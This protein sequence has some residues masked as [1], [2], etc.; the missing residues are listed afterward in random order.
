V[1]E[2]ISYGMA[3]KIFD[4][5]I[6]NAKQSYA[7]SGMATEYAENFAREQINELT[8]IKEKREHAEN[9]LQAVGTE[10][11]KLKE[12]IEKLVG[13]KNEQEKLQKLQSSLEQQLNNDS[14]LFTA[15]L[16]HNSENP[17]THQVLPM[18][19][20]SINIKRNRKSEDDSWSSEGAAPKE[21]KG[22]EIV[23]SITVLTEDEMLDLIE[24][25]CRILVA[26]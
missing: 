17:I 15:A 3:H 22:C 12:T 25:D 4:S 13:A 2:G 10:N 16:I 26:K 5:K 8:S 1:D 19:T 7:G 20:E 21:K 24:D 18:A 14:V 6:Q 23:Q 11:Q 9:I